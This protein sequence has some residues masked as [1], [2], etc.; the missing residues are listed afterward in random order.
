MRLTVGRLPDIDV[1]LAVLRAP[2]LVLPCAPNC[3]EAFLVQIG[4]DW[5]IPLVQ[6]GADWYIQPLGR[7]SRLSRFSRVGV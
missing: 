4:A 6:I 2:R 5:Y 1:I 3:G 7:L